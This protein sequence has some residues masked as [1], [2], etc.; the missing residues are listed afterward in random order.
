MELLDRQEKLKADNF[1]LSGTDF[2]REFTLNSTDIKISFMIPMHIIKKA[3]FFKI[4]YSDIKDKDIVN[5]IISMLDDYMELDNMQIIKTED[6]RKYAKL[7]YKGIAKQIK[8]TLS[9][10]NVSSMRLN[11]N[12]GVLT[13]MPTLD[14]HQIFGYTNID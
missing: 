6:C 9:T 2:K 5:D 10:S 1:I 4:K 7:I 3:D 12:P 14:M 13:T 8:D 11:I